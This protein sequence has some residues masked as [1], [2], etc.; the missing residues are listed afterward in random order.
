MTI[1]LNDAPS[2]HAFDTARPEWTLHDHRADDWVERARAVKL[3]DVLSQRGILG[4]LKKRGVEFIGP[5]PHCRG[6]D[7]FSINC[8]DQ[9]FLCRQC[10]PE[11]GGGS[12][13]LVKFLD[14]CDFLAAV[15]TLTGEPRP[16]RNRSGF[17]DF[18][19]GR[20]KQQEAPKPEKP[21]K[22]AP[23][24]YIY[25]QPDGSPYLKVR[26]YYKDGEKKFA[27]YHWDGAWEKGGP[28]GPKI[29]YRLPEIL[30]S[31]HNDI[32]I[33][34]G[35]NCVDCLSMRGF[36]ATTNSG[37]ADNGTG[38]KWTT[39]LNPYFK[40]RNVNILPDNDEPGAKHAQFVASQLKPIANCVR[41]VNLPGLPH[42]GDIV[43]WFEADRTNEQLVELTK[44]AP[45]FNPASVEQPDTE[46]PNT[47]SADQTE[48][49]AKVSP[50]P[51]TFFDDCGA[52]IKKRH[53]QKDLLARGETSAIIGPPKIG[54]SA[55]VTEI[56]VFC[57]A[58][59]D[60]RGHKSKEACGVV[61]FALERADQYKR[62][63]HAYKL[64]DNL[65]G[66]P[67]AVA[68]KVID[69]LD[70]KCMDLIAETVLA[71]EQQFGC[72]VGLIIIDTYSKGIA[73]GGG[74]EDKARDANRAAANLRLLQFHLDLHVLLVGHTGKNEDRGARGS[75]AHLADVDV[76]VQI[77]GNG[78]VKMAKVIEANDQPQRVLAEYCLEEHELGRD[79][80]GD[81]ITTAIISDDEV[82]FT[83]KGS[84]P[85]GLNGEQ[86]RAMELL[87]RCINDHGRP[88]PASNDYPQ[89][90]RI[91]TL[92]EWH[93]ACERG[94]LSSADKKES[95][96]R[97]FRRAKD[98]LQTMH[99]IACLDGNVWPVID[100]NGA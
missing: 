58:G 15:E 25:Q 78:P 16:K 48:T 51:L 89:N 45:V 76:M 91:V 30:A 70:A 52:V 49:K 81:P 35:E 22:A 97:V 6:H 54:K 83:T 41:I 71:A 38:S 7:R 80:D 27:Q 29:P 59:R 90:I 66:L 21:K 44:A 24:D 82:K 62:R 63:L 95:R 88:P 12:I 37:G 20:G 93:T 31:N 5:C 50:I 57:A 99:K 28:D 10:F 61:I 11:D 2:Q 72:R 13:S 33:A 98:A 94:G 69:L 19:L 4:T 96:D 56:V 100:S 40:D 85:A 46:Q 55:L 60:W 8:R 47:D 73:A 23:A 17:N 79:E 32:Y 9:V 67:I 39:D 87:Y 75:N 92:E 74:D 34:E 1:D 64:R 42:K 65:K 77:S 68:G 18:D 26:R 53:I 84:K 86:R 3:E 43:E 36:V 14:D